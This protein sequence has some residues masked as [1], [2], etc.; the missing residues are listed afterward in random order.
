MKTIKEK[1]NAP[2]QNAIAAAVN[3]DMR[4]WPPVCI[5]LFYQPE[6]PARIE[7]LYSENAPVKHE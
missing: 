1:L 5:T 3:K 2:L 6:R 7:A 4:E